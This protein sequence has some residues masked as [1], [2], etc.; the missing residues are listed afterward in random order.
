MEIEVEEKIDLIAVEGGGEEGW[1]DERWKG[2]IRR[3]RE[4]EIQ[5]LIEKSNPGT[6]EKGKG[7]L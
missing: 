7:R 6:R 1:F 5:V 2:T 4:G 3:A